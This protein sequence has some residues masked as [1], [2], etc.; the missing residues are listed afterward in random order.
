MLRLK[1]LKTC[2][3]S[4]INVYVPHNHA[5]QLDFWAKAITNRHTL[6]LPLP[7]FVLGDFNV[8][9]DSIDRAPAHHDIPQATEAMREVR[10]VWN[11]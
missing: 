7:D 5:V 9:E 6:H 1:W 4:I 11:I 2:E 8:T 10:C 3:T